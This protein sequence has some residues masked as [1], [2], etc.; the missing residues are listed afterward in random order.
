[1]NRKD[2][3]YFEMLTR[4]VEFGE[5]HMNLFPK[6][7]LGGTTFAA[8]GAALSKASEHAGGQVASRNAVH[9]RTKAR[10]GAR[11]ALRAQLQRM[12]DTARAI[13]IDTSGLEG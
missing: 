8:L 7:T 1:M 5:A 12:S 4:V 10:D 13:A 9:A 6:D 3:Q 11:E 2:F